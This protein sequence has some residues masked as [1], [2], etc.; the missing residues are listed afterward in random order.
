MLE[1][2]LI[3][4]E[5]AKDILGI[6]ADELEELIS[7]GALIP[8]T[9]D[10]KKYFPEEEVRI[11]RQKLQ[12]YMSV[13]LNPK[14][15]IAR[16]TSLERKVSLLENQLEL[17]LTFFGLTKRNFTQAAQINL[18]EFAHRLSR[19][20]FKQR[21]IPNDVNNILNELISF[22]PIHLRLIGELL[23][24]DPIRYLVDLLN[25]ISVKMKYAP[26]I[27]AKIDLVIQYIIS[28]G[29][30]NGMDSKEISDTK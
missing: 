2:D 27:V 7:Y 15:V 22:G 12:Y 9:I 19:T 13:E 28:L 10:G 18:F 5:E 8:F 25:E 11:V 21:P 26:G 1:L 23:D 20:A 16:I 24:T 29:G 14:E 30:E 17:L 3:T 6:T 4:L